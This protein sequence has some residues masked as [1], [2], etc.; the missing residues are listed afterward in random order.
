MASVA[1]AFLPGGGGDARGAVERILAALADRSPGRAVAGGAVGAVGAG[2][3]DDSM[4]RGLIRAAS[5][6]VTV[7]FDAPGWLRSRLEQQLGV[8]WPAGCE[9]LLRCLSSLRGEVHCVATVGDRGCVLYRAPMSSRPLFY[10]RGHGGALLAATQIRGIRAVWERRVSLAGLA[11]FLVPQLCDPAGS[12]WRGIHRLPPGHAL[13]Y[14]GGEVSIRRVAGV[15]AADT[16][17]VGRGELVAEFRARLI[18][19]VDRCAPGAAEILLSGGIDSSALACAR[20]ASRGADRVRG[21]ALTYD[22]NL[23]AC[24]ERRYV[25][26]VERA[27]GIAVS[28][29]SGNRLLPLV[30]D[31]PEGD[32]PEPWA[33]AARNWALLRRV[34]A[35]SPTPGTVLTG[36]GGDEL[37]LGQVFAVADRHA[38]GDTEGAARELATFPKP[39]RVTR[40]MDGLLRG[41]YDRPATRTMRAL[42]EIPPWLDAGYVTDHGLIGR[43]AAGYP[44]LGE[45]GRLAV[46]YSRG[47]I[48]E[49]GAAGRV[50]CGGWWDDTARRAGM[51]IA[52]P[53]LDADLAALTWALP[54]ELLRDGGLEKVVLRESLAGLLPAS[55]A[56]RRDKAEALALLHAGLGERADSLRAIAHGGPLVEQA[57]IQPGKLLRGIEQYLA[58]R[59]ELG[60]ALW[61]TNAV[62][63]WLR[64]RNGHLS[65][66]D[67]APER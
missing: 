22:E 47:L 1:L 50:Q 37:L 61:A 21:F 10:A 3:E 36:E 65:K 64:P 41:E 2:A 24:D 16:A 25:D 44:R 49:A 60:P 19:A 46:S 29:M 58:G 48:A 35:E 8:G 13:L 6:Q 28:R 51:R 11:P 15:D 45:A 42:G 66:E 23:A 62:D 5:A 33:Y 18:R 40:V 4:A 54:P 9:Q 59:R 30:A 57:V 26:D 31:F 20:A 63:R 43:L 7:A 56:A 38:R 14:D 32:E 17:G 12:A 34:T 53:F 67:H 39:E 27:S 52:Y 55:V